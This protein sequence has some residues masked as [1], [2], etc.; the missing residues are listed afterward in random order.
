VYICLL[1]IFHM[2]RVYPELNWYTVRSMDGLS[3]PQRQ[4]ELTFHSS[5]V[6]KG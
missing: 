4:A 1:E 5:G 6:S 3:T 2:K